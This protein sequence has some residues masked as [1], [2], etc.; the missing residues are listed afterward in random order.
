VSEVVGLDEKQI[1]EVL[2]DTSL[3][4]TDQQV[5][6]KLIIENNKKLEKEIVDLVTKNIVDAL[7]DQAIYFH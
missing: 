4:I 5:I 7:N 2:K 3:N 6:T 1:F